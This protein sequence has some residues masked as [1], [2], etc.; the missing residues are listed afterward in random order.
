MTMKVRNQ[1]LQRIFRV[2]E[3]QPVIEPR[4]QMGEVGF[5]RA[6]QRR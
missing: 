1:R 6:L 5:P 4:K 3:F 2:A